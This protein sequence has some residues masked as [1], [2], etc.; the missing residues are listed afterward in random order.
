MKSSEKSIVLVDDDPKI[1][2]LLKRMLERAGFV[3]DAFEQAAD[4]LK[5][6]N[7]GRSNVT[8][9]ICDVAM[10]GMSGFDLLKEVKQQSRTKD[11]P[12][13]FLSAFSDEELL[14]KALDQGAVDYVIK[15][16]SQNVL[17]AKIRSLLKAFEAN[18]S[19]S[20]TILKGG[21]D[22]KPIGEVLAFC[23]REGLNGVLKVTRP[24]GTYGIINYVKGHPENILVFNE[25]QICTHSDLDA[26]ETIGS[27]EK[28]LYT[29][30]RG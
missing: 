21:L 26:F 5:F 28:G 2:F 17:V 14:V 10:P 16:V 8:M 13:L 6:L 25:R 30:K 3:T 24:D 11:L 9:I 15:P 23:E 1:L 4:A 20:T 7:S 22:E 18:K 27:W 12:F 19:K 29:I